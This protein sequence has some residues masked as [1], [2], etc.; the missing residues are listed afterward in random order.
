MRRLVWSVA[1]GWLG[2]LA[3]PALAASGGTIRVESPAFAAGGKIPLE[4]SCEGKGV[5]PPIRWSDV[6]PETQSLAV[7]VDDP[8]APNGPYVHLAVF[9]LPSSARSLPGD[10]DGQRAL[11][12]RLATNSKGEPGF[13]PVCPPT[14]KH[15]YRFRV[16][17]LDRVLSLPKGVSANELEN[18]M[19]GHILAKG[20]LD[21]TYQKSER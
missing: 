19:Q 20:E 1:A 2:L 21:G 11:A 4:N 10:L 8:D 7:I 6:P 5:S 16:F 14:G 15:T 3:V 13:S 12:A 17:A 18:A 9:D